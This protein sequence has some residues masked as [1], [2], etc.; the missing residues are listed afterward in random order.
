MSPRFRAFPVRPSPSLVLST[1]ALGLVV[2]GCE[3]Q[4]LPLGSSPLGK[5]DLSLQQG[6]PDDSI[7]TSR[8]DF[9]VPTT[10]GGP[11]GGLT[12]AELA[13][14]HDGLEELSS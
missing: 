12:G 5:T 10:L 8:L 9:V 14:F 11:I 1:F 6:T 7:E 2:A 13:R 3:V 4:R